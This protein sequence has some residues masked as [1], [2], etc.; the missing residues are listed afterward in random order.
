MNRKSI[1][2]FLSYSLMITPLIAADFSPTS[3]NPPSAS[4]ASSSNSEEVVI[5]SPP[6]GW[7]LAD[8]SV[9][10][11]T[12]KIM[13]V[14]KGKQAFPPSMNLATQPYKKTLKQYLKTVKAINESQGSEWKDLGP[15]QTEAGLASLSQV[16]RKTEWG[17]ERMMHVILLKNEKIYILTASALKEEFPQ[18]YKD[19]FAA[20][21]SLRVNKD[22]FDLV[23]TGPRRTQAQK[24]YENVQNQ[25]VTLLKE[26]QSKRPN[27]SIENLKKELFES[28][29]F[30]KTVWTPFKSMLEK[31]YSDMGA[32]W[33][34][35]L[36]EKTENDLF[37]AKL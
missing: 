17:E 21:R 36:L 28:E 32:Q 35:F 26:H 37:D 18:F 6:S 34:A 11:A 29:S 23:P 13:V 10:P 19:F 4:E 24:A 7:R 33:Q 16:D 20:M 25:W 30:Q 15:I 1:S 5:F 9:L 27:E 12:V 14:G 2:L 22:V 31:Q 3:P 8:T